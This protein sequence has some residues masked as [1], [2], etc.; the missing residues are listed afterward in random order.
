MREYISIVNGFDP[1]N[2]RYTMQLGTKII[3]VAPMAVS[4]FSIFKYKFITS[5]TSISSENVQRIL[6]N[7]T[8]QYVY[9]KK[10]TNHH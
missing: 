7:S 8:S 5:S 9:D 2:T 6:F 4:A 1:T 3:S 10:N